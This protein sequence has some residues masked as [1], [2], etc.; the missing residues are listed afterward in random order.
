ML[1]RRNA[2]ANSDFDALG[3]VGVGGNLA[4]ELCRFVNQGLHFFVGILRRPDRV[5]FAQDAAGSAS[6]YHVCAVFD[7]VPDCGAD[8]FGAVGDTLRNVALYQSWL[9]AILITMS[10]RNA[11]SMTGSHHSRS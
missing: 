7:H 3:A 11:D 5:A 6:L 4:A 1:D 2:R 9:K 10:A 8:L